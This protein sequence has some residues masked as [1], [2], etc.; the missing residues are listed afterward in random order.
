VSLSRRIPIRLPAPPSFS[1]AALVLL[2][3]GL[4]L[5]LRL[6]IDLA[7]PG[8][9]GGNFGYD[10]G[11]YYTAADSLLHGRLPYRDFVLLHPPG[12]MLS[13]TPF[14]ALG[15]LTSDH[16]GFVAGNTTFAVLGSINAVLVY[17]IGLRAGFPRR[18][19]AFGG[20]FYAV[21]FGAVEAE[22][23]AR[24]EPLGSFAFLLGL[25]AL[26]GGG[27]ALGAGR[28]ISRR[29]AGLAGIGLG[30][31]VC[32]KIWWIVP[33][34]VVAAYLLRTRPTRRAAGHLALGA[35]A[36][37]LVIDG[38][39]FAA[40][41]SAM[42]RMVVL[43][44]TGRPTSTAAIRRLDQLSSLRAAFPTVAGSGRDIGLAILVGLVVAAAVAA[45][46]I[47]PARLIV[48]LAAAQFA[49][50]AAAPTYF[51]FY[52]GYPA[53]ALSLV[54]AGAS[55]APGSCAAVRRLRGFVGGGLVIGAAGLTAVAVFARPLAATSPFPGD[56]LADR[57]TGLRCVMADSPM[58]LIELDV[59]SRDLSHHC[60]NWVDVSG[61]TYDVDSEGNRPRPDNIR[62]QRAVRRYLLSGNAVIL[63]RPGTGLSTA[64][65]RAIT[66]HRAL[67]SADGYTV[68]LVGTS[69]VSRGGRGRPPGPSRR[70]DGR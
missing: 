50:L 6:G 11:V 44:Q 10:A 66:N 57:V 29:R 48:L 55:A 43:D 67:V 2:I 40:A 32:V 37:G 12:I 24:L 58:A 13:L 60:A 41:P 4:A 16:A 52:S 26:S 17:T 35:L 36:A 45:W 20:L 62:W 3:F 69:K 8:G 33:L 39:F 28:A 15:R 49:V 42:W 68:Y 1:A 22:N 65:R 21:W 64:T 59:L 18:A 46:S 31:A 70:A 54:V 51:A 7:S 34:A 25:L 30:V 23:S 19:A 14:A 61:R 53:A 56:R 38:P 63:I 9:A 5:A 27:A 47:R